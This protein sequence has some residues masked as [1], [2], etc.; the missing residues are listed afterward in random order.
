MTKLYSM[1]GRMRK[2]HNWGLMLLGQSPSWRKALL[3]L[4]TF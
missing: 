1:I 3:V 2:L 4:F